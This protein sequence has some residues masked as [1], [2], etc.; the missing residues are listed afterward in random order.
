M[1][2]RRLAPSDE[3]PPTTSHGRPGRDSRNEPARPS[4][5]RAAATTPGNR[6]RCG[7]RL[8]FSEDPPARTG[9]PTARN[10]SS[11]HTPTT[12]TSER[13]ANVAHRLPPTGTRAPRASTAA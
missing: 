13:W 1:R 2:L 6:E 4:H 8:S 7:E 10:E 12:E 9:K 11:A 3:R 5:P